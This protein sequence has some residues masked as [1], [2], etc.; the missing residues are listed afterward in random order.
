MRYRLEVLDDDGLVVNNVET[1]LTLGS[2]I[3]HFA[4]QPDDP[5]RVMI[6]G[7][8]VVSNAG[9]ELA[10]ISHITVQSPLSVAAIAVANHE[11]WQ[12]YPGFN[13]QMAERCQPN[14]IEE[15]L[16]ALLSD[17]CA[18]VAAGLIQCG[19]AGLEAGTKERASNQ[20]QS[21]KR[22]GSPV[23]SAVSMMSGVGARIHISQTQRTKARNYRLHKP[24]SIT[25]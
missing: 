9:I 1:G 17:T 10:R 5:D 25:A 20:S 15:L 14:R 11:R 4:T 23:A 16:G 21:C 12:D 19:S 6:S 24:P 3:P 22:S 7:C 13:T 2:V 18:E 8:T